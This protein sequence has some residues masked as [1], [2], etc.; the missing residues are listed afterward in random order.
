M[1]TVIRERE[2]ETI[3]SLENTRVSRKEKLDEV[4]KQVQQLEKQFKQAAE[5]ATEL[6]QRSSSA[7][8]MRS[9]GKLEERLEELGKTQF[10][11]IPA[12]SF[13]KFVS[14]CKLDNL[15]LGKIRS[16]SETN[17][18][19]STI[20]GLKQTFQAGVEAEI[21]ICSQTREG[22]FSNRQPEDHVEVQV[23]PAEQLA[24]L[25]V[26]EQAGGKFPVK[27]VPKLPGSYNIS[28]K[29]NGDNLDQSPFTIRIQERKLEIVGELDLKNES[30]KIPAGVAVSGEGLIAVADYSKHCFLVFDSRGKFNRLVGCYGDNPGEL[31]SPIVVTFMNDDEILVADECNHRIQQFNVHSGNFVN[32]FGRYGS[33]DGEFRHPVS[34]CMDGKGHVIVAEYNN[35]R[36]QV[37]TK[38]GIP[39]LKFGD[40]GPEKLG[41][42]V[43]CV[44]YKDTFIVAD[45]ANGCLKVFDCS[46][47]FLRKIGKKVKE[48][49]TF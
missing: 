33:G 10:P 22:Q 39:V 42:P 15:S 3:T 4:K 7:D 21:S 35:H 31:N 16:G 8:I 17:P 5:F 48:L 34:V 36:V 29:I 26:N 19:R 28:T 38:D 2:R 44:Y 24:S 41:F 12:S 23:D 20:E 6:A 47:K 46:G 45:S 43:G 14:T 18:I 9:K 37:L 30:M 32:S 40:R 49:G 13:V 11:K 27:F 25:I 1:I